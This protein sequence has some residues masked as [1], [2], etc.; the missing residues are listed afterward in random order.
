MYKPRPD[1]CKGDSRARRGIICRQRSISPVMLSPNEVIPYNRVMSLRP[2]VFTDLESFFFQKIALT[3]KRSVV[4][5]R[6][7]K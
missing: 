1:N 7:Y 2:G 5:W 6:Y 4:S 3:P